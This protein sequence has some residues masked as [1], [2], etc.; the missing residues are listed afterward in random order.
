MS[1]LL[2]QLLLPSVF[3]TVPACIYIQSC[4]CD[5]CLP[6]A[7]P[8]AVPAQQQGQA[9]PAPCASTEHDPA[10]SRSQH[11]PKGPFPALA[12]A[13]SLHSLWNPA[14]SPKGEAAGLP[15][16]LAHGRCFLTSNTPCL[17][18]SPLC[19]QASAINNP[20]LGLK[21]TKKLL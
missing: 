5:R 2:W 1:W 10:S 20:F 4:L 9:D 19:Q 6:A 11:I 18:R 13:G 7:L 17:T 16:N 21:A 8:W 14:I 15:S 3:H 12:A